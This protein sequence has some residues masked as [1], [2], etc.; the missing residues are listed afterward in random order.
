MTVVVYEGRAI[1]RE[2]SRYR[3]RESIDQSVS[4]HLSIQTHAGVEI[5]S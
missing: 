4:V 3:Q 1:A 2:S 5:D